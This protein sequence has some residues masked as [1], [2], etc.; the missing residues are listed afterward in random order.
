MADHLPLA[1]PH[2]HALAPLTPSP[3]CL[4]HAPRRVDGV[5]HEE[6]VQKAGCVAIRHMLERSPKALLRCVV[7]DRAKAADATNAAGPVQRCAALE[8]LAATAR[9][10]PSDA[11]VRAAQARATALLA[12]AATVLGARIAE[13]DR[14]T[15][16]PSKPP[17]RQLRVLLDAVAEAAAPSVL[18]LLVTE[19]RVDCGLKVTDH[20][21]T[22]ADSKT[23]GRAA[24]QVFGSA[25]AGELVEGL[26]Q[27]AALAQLIGSTAK[28]GDDAMRFTTAR[29]MQEALGELRGLLEIA[30]WVASADVAALGGGTGTGA[31]AGMPDTASWVHRY[32]RSLLQGGLCSLARA[33][34]DVDESGDLRQLGVDK[35]PAKGL[36]AALEVCGRLLALGC[37]ARR[38]MPR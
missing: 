14:T 18:R 33:Y 21:C 3:P 38:C 28:A 30:E 29:M 13:S 19:L 36:Y 16:S 25:T 11:V 4:S 9:M 34:E 32:L 26:E 5:V 22:V 8:A 10:L 12:A 2:A 31:G 7:D 1:A 24:L 15:N 35:I 17:P 6:S 23:T 27:V 37:A 20:A